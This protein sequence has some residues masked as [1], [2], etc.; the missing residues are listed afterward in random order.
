MSALADRLRE[1]PERLAALTREFRVPAASL[2]VLE[3]DGGVF[4]TACGVLNVRTGVEATPD[5]VFQMGSIT[6]V[7]TTTLVMQLVDEGRLD[8]DARVADVLP[9]FGLA[10]AAAARAITL[11]QL[12]THTSGID[13]DQFAD[14]GRGDDAIERFVAHLHGVGCVH[15]PGARFSY[16]NAGF[17]V[18]GRL[19]EVLR[20]ATYDAV[21][22]ERILQPLGLRA[23]G[24]LPEQAILHRAAAGHFA[25]A[26]GAPQ[27]VP[28]WSLQHSNAPA[29]ATPFTTATD[30]LAFARMHLDD[31][32]GV[33][34][35]RSAR[36]M[37]ERHL[38]LHGSA[39]SMADAWGLGWMLKDGDA[40]TLVCHSGVTIG[41]RAWLDVVPDRRVGVAL[42]TNGGDANAL[43]SR[44]RTALLREVAGFGLPPLPAIDAALRV[45]ASRYLGVYER[46]GAR[47]EVVPCGTGIGARIRAIWF[48]MAPDPPPLPLRATGRDRFRATLPGSVD[49]VTVGFA[50]A[51]A[52][53]GARFVEMQGRAHPRVS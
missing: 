49:D 26:D 7:W 50:E 17:V 19:V 14:T 15:A 11:R 48:S 42:L 9:A 31:G 37:R 5:S 3:E 25:G 36:S 34:S 10:D 22:R 53:G 2:A 23:T 28:I 12:L 20:G 6:K 43:A 32:A 27:V 40:G 30:L 21:L 35:A 52:R 44:V 47:I 4:A 24:T 1:W 41:Q 16:C 18:A 46:A 33:L 13:G 8:L 45:D 29:G 39:G 38:E 51:G